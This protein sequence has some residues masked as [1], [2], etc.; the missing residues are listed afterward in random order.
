M[1]SLCIRAAV[2]LSF[3]LAFL[4]GAYGQITPSA[5]AYTNSSDPGSNHGA[6]PTLN[7]NGATEITYIQFPLSSIPPGATVSQAT[8]KLY[9]DAVTTAGSF[10]VNYVTGAWAESAITGELA[11]ALGNMIASNVLVSAGDKNQY[12]LINVTPAVEAWLNGSEANNGIALVANGA[13]SASFDSKENTATGH[14]PELDLVLATAGNLQWNGANLL[15]V[16]SSAAPGGIKSDGITGSASPNIVS[17]G[18]GGG[19]GGGVGGVSSVTSPDGTISVSPTSGA[20]TVSAAP[21][22]STA[23][24]FATTAAG[25][26]QTNAEN[27]AYSTFLPLAGGRVTGG[28]VVNQNVGI[29]TA[30]PKAALDVN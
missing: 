21:A 29:G 4:A 15:C 1:K 30:T 18:G 17:C 26:A 16:Q 11:P 2:V 19:G 24:A 8:L 12:I 23:E 3:T 6:G 20:V 22:V 27:Y 28:L 5:D 7:V 10:N 13:L 14:S 9:V 25:T